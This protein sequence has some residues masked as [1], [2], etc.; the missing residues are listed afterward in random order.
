MGY[1]VTFA[2]GILGLSC[3]FG[4]CGGGT[5]GPPRF[6]VSGT[7]KFKGAAV[8][9]GEIC[10]EPDA[11]KGN[12][13]PMVVI[14]IKNGSY[15]TEATHGMVSGP[16]VVR[17]SGTD[18]VPTTLPGGMDMPNGKSLFTEYQT[19]GTVATDKAGTK[20]DFD[21]PEAAPARRK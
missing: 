12:T 8:P 17:I 6:Q 15:A 16:V 1:R 10:L 18:G 7:V 11:S 13:G 14:P 9:A 3:L 5:D 2:I 4:G 21:V 20:L 19:T